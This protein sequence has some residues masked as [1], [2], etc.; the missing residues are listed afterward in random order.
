MGSEIKLRSSD[1]MASTFTTKSLKKEK[2]LWSGKR[3]KRV[4]WV[5]VLGMYA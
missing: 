5:K 3:V 2:A 1:M 4:C